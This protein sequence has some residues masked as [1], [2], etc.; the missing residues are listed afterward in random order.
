MRYLPPP[1]RLRAQDVSLGRHPPRPHSAP[2][3]RNHSSDSERRPVSPVSFFFL[4]A[5]R[6]EPENLSPALGHHQARL[7]QG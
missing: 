3:L 6:I 4:K 1:G 7:T 5:D 2:S